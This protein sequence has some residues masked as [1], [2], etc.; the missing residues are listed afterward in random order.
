MEFEGLALPI[1]LGG[2]G[3]FVGGVLAI[4]QVEERSP[5]LFRGKLDVDAVV[6]V[7]PCGVQL[8][9]EIETSSV[10]LVDTW[11]FACEPEWNCVLCHRR[12]TS[13]VRK[14]AELVRMCGL[15]RPQVAET[16]A[17][18]GA[19]ITRGESLGNRCR[20]GRSH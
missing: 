3:S 13:W 15:L 4:S 7:T 11:G 6:G 2:L 1:K 9:A 14:V 5:I 19:E 16:D 18:I 17:R 8:F 12:L 20:S 10:S